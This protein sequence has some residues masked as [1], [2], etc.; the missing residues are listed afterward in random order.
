MALK[1]ISTPFLDP[2]FALELTKIWQMF[3]FRV[4]AKNLDLNP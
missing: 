4:F 1:N 2:Y 3:L